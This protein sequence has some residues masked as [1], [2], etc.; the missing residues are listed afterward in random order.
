MCMNVCVI[1]EEWPG[2]VGGGEG[3][4]G[5]CQW[6][7]GEGEWAQ[8]SGGERSV[9]SY[10][11]LHQGNVLADPASNVMTTTERVLPNN[12]FY[13]NCLKVLSELVIGP[14]SQET[15]SYLSS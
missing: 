13:G 6:G 9:G 11:S 8:A 7:G 15:C 14:C 2:P 3:E 1:V 10:S 5:P 12:H 4:V